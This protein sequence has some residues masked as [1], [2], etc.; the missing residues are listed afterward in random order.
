MAEHLAGLSKPF[1]VKLLYAAVVRPIHKLNCGQLVGPLSCLRTSGAA[2]PSFL[3]T[4]ASLE[5]ITVLLPIH[6]AVVRIR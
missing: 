4:S 6:R 5:D 1:N 2:R 3:F